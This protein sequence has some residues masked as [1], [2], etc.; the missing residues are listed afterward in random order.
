[1]NYINEAQADMVEA[2]AMA[3]GGIR[4]HEATIGENIER[5]IIEKRREIASLEEVR[6]KLVKA[7]L[8]DVKISDLRQAMQF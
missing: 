5:R 7:N 1:M 8:I 2:K 4:M 3:V 6:E